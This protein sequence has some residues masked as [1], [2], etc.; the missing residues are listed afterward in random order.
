MSEDPTGSALGGSTGTP[1]SG[2]STGAAV[3][4]GATGARA[5]GGASVFGRLVRGVLLEHDHLPPSTG[6]EIDYLRTQWGADHTDPE[7]DPHPQ[8]VTAAELPPAVDAYTKSEADA[9]FVDAT[10]DALSG[11]LVVGTAAGN[12]ALA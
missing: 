11:G 5:N 4:A 9:R 12:P 2:G 6:G 3:D 8:Y 7:G 1:A 10:G